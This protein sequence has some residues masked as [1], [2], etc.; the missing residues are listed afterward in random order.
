MRQRLRGVSAEAARA[1]GQAAARAL[2]A[3]PVWF[4][5][6]SVLVYSAVRG[7][8]D[9]R[10]IAEAAWQAGKRVLLPCPD[11]AALALGPREW[12]RG[13]ALVRGPYGIPV[14]LAPAS[15]DADGVDLAIVPGLAFDTAGRRLGNGLGYYDRWL[16]AHPEATA[17]GLAHAWQVVDVVPA[18]RH[19]VCM[20]ALLTP[21]G[22]RAARPA[23]P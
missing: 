20:T 17:V 13:G 23:A 8:L 11:T 9:P 3:V 12:L 6:R 14:P 7:E 22:W 15:G 2:T 21:E 5:A 10:A 4:C 18:D 16:A 1:G 19:D